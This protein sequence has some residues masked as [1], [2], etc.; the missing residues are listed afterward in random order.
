MRQSFLSAVIEYLGEYVKRIVIG[1]GVG[2][3]VLGLA[4]CGSGSFASAPSTSAPTSSAAAP[5]PAPSTP[6]PSVSASVTA[7]YPLPTISE[8]QAQQFMQKFPSITKGRE[9]RYIASDIR[10]GCVAVFRSGYTPNLNNYLL[11]RFS[12]GGNQ[13]SAG[14]VQQVEAWLRSN[15]PQ[16]GQ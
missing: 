14:E 5:T 11:Q 3:A 4:A 10:S 9:A 1:T 16:P 13:V 2:L 15:C 6:E 12:G 8:A 7:Q